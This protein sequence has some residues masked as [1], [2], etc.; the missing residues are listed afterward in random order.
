MEHPIHQGSEAWHKLRFGRPTASEFD[1][2]VTPLGKVK[3][4]EGPQS[5][6]YRKLAEHI[7]GRSL[8]EGGSWAMEQGGILESEAIPFYEFT[9]DAEVRRIGFVT[10]DDMRIGCSPD[11]L[12]G[13]DS[14]IEAKCPLPQTHLRY[15]LEGGVPKEYVA[16]V[17]GCMF[18]TQRPR[19]VFLSYCRK[20]PPHIVHV[21]RDEAFQA[22][23]AEATSGFLSRFDAALYKL[24]TLTQATRAVKRA[25][26]EAAL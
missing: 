12:I 21:E 11:G 1:N 25:T 9:F 24:E 10:T 13:D 20:M 5:Y 14:G 3:T 7:L 23:L 16:Q 18:V 22:A 2:L 15:L 17:Q 19:W 26:M 6:L 4:G 8:D